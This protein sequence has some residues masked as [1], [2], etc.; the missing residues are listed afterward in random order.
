MQ[1]STKMSSAGGIVYLK[2]NIEYSLIRVFDNI[3][4]GS[5]YISM[6]EYGNAREVD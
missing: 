5:E 2:K 6:I 3:S 4:M 1:F